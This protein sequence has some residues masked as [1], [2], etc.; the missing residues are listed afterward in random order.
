MIKLK[1]LITEKLK[2]NK[3]KSL[4]KPELSDFRDEIYDMIKTSYAS[5]G[6]HPKIKSPND[7]SFNDI[8]YWD[9]VDVDGDGAPDAISGAKKKI[10]GKKYMVGATDGSKPAKRAYVGNRIKMLKKSGNFAELSHRIA[11]FAE[12]NGVPIVDDEKLVRTILR[13]KDINWL[14]DGWYERKIGSKKFKKR[15]FGVPKV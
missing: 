9:A 7:I 14:G 2:K 10:G 3:W 15:M 8:N 1:D 4:T 12:S 5:L 6:G 13:G 11:D